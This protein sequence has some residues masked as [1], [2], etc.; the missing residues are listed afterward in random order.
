MTERPVKALLIAE[1]LDTIALLEEAL[2]EIEEI[3]YSRGWMQPCELVPADELGEALEALAAEH[4]D[5][6]LL[7]ASL[8]GG[9]FLNA[10][11]RLRASAPE[12]PV[13]ILAEPDDEPMVISLLR[14]GAQDYLIKSE[15]DCLPL[16]RTL[17]AAIERQRVR[18]ALESLAFTDELTGVFTTAG[19]H[20]LAERHRRLAHAAGLHVQLLLVEIDGPDEIQD[21]LRT[22]GILREMF[23][24]T[25]LVAR[26][27]QR[28]FAVLAVTEEPAGFTAALPGLPFR[29]AAVAWPPGSEVSLD[30]LLEECERALCENGRSTTDSMQHVLP[31]DD[32]PRRYL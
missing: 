19:L 32:R 16:A 27:T 11:S 17:R 25:G 9:R 31:L 13:V 8:S 2:L 20:S 10:F 1:D 12:L 6:I 21:V 29:A 18:N 7:D 24:Q 26:A 15:I 28:R 4:F 30:H 23:D 14:R 3:R 5:V 22:A